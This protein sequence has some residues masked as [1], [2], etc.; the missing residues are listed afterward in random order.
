MPNIFGIVDDNLVIGYGDDGTDHDAM[1]QKV[2]QR[3]EEVTLKLNKEKCHFRCTSI[4]FFREVIL[5]RGVK[6]DPKKIKALMD[7][8]PPNNE[9]VLQAFLALLT[10]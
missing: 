10:T 4:P 9:K 5:R 6:P 8:A 3:C 1:V 7:M 2:L